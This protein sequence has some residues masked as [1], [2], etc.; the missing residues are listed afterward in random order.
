MMYKQARQGLSI[1]ET[2]R[3]LWARWAFRTLKSGGGR[4]EG[5]GGTRAGLEL[6]QRPAQWPGPTRALLLPVSVGNGGP[7]SL[8][9]SGWIAL[10]HV[11]TS[12]LG[13]DK[14]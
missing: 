14:S 4:G 2:R 7:S 5:G 1:G 13:R 12:T 9:V 8:S 11:S 3:G 10:P 6:D